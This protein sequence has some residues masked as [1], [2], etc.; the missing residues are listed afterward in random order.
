MTE[1]AVRKKV[2]A[3]SLQWLQGP[4]IVLDGGCSG[5][6]VDAVSHTGMHYALSECTVPMKVDAVNLQWL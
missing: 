3:V 5:H 6:A 1:D 2:D 4:G